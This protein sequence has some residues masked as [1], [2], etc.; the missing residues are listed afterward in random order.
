M[1]LP[2]ETV[3]QADEDWNVVSFKMNFYNDPL[4][5]PNFLMMIAM[6]FSP[7]EIQKKF[8]KPKIELLRAVIHFPENNFLHDY[9]SDMSGN[10]VQY[11]CNILDAKDEP[12]VEVV[13]T[14]VAF[15]SFKPIANTRYLDYVRFEE[16]TVKLL[17]ARMIE[18][19]FWPANAANSGEMTMKATLTG[20][21]KA[22]E[23]E[24]TFPQGNIT[25]DIV[26]E[27]ALAGAIGIQEC[28]VDVTVNNSGDKVVAFEDPGA[29]KFSGPFVA[30]LEMEPPGNI[31]WELP[32]AA[33][34]IPMYYKKREKTQEFRFT[35]GAGHGL[36]LENLS[37]VVNT[38]MVGEM[39]GGPG[40]Y[41]QKTFGKVQFVY[42]VHYVDLLE[43]EIN[44]LIE[45][46]NTQRLNAM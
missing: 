24:I 26:S 4:E 33:S 16:G 12:D 18:A 17:E 7:K 34:G 45:K 39:Q 42:R 9:E 29:I 15:P 37:L 2:F 31:S 32:N 46:Q 14:P 43:E 41:P 27:G 3:H 22:P 44:E 13:K 19:A 5:D 8:R 30:E 20:E 25:G 1:D 11:Y 40:T 36:L 35:D 21:I 38:L 23:A 6:Q 10:W 28:A